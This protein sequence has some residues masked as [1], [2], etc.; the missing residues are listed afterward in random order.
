MEFILEQNNPNP[1]N[2][3][4]KIKSRL[5]KENFATLSIYNLMGQIIKKLMSEKLQ[6]GIYEK[7]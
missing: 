4:T 6:A 7:F 1:F 2:P 5:P 3:I